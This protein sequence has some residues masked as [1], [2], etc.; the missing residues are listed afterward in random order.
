M[1]IELNVSAEG[2]KHC[3][4]WKFLIIALFLQK[5]F[6]ESSRIFRFDQ[7][8]RI[9]LRSAGTVRTICLC[10]MESK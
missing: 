5:E 3:N 7:S 1:R 10:E 2:V 9:G 6:A 8:L 4:N